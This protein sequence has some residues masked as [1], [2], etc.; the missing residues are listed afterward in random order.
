MTVQH[1]N[2]EEL[3][4]PEERHGAADA[5][6]LDL[7]GPWKVMQGW[8]GGLLDGAAYSLRCFIQTLAAGCQPASQPAGQAQQHV[9]VDPAT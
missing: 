3:G 9:L 6:F 1:R 5:V 7:P 2:I 8:R 4:F